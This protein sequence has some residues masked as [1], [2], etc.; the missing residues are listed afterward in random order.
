M[1][2]GTLIRSSLLP[3]RRQLWGFHTRQKYRND[4]RNEVG[5]LNREFGAGDD[6]GRRKF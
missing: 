1:V 3:A 2:L 5:R 6:E 4:G